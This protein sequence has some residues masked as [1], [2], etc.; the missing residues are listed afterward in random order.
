MTLTCG[1]AE[2]DFTTSP[3]FPSVPMPTANTDPAA[4]SLGFPTEY[5][6]L[7]ELS[8]LS[9]RRTR[10][11]AKYAGVNQSTR[12]FATKSR[13]MPLRW[14]SPNI[15]SLAVRYR[16][17]GLRTQCTGISPQPLKI[18]AGSSYSGYRG[19]APRTGVQ[20]KPFDCAIHGL[21]QSRPGSESPA[22]RAVRIAARV[23][24]TQGIAR[25]STSR[26]CRSS[27]IRLIASLTVLYLFSVNLIHL[28]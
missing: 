15:R 2:A 13:Y 24:R 10:S 25:K 23:L 8:E 6:L 7:S 1:L 9:S 26:V 3:T 11:L 20:T 5:S 19:D 21:R 17:T 22:A 16:A 27:S 4:N 12:L 14:L 28:P 18:P